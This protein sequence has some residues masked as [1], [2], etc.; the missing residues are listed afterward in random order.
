MSVAWNGFCFFDL[1]IKKHYRFD[2]RVCIFIDIMIGLI[3]AVTGFLNFAYDAVIYFALELA[4]G[5]QVRLEIAAIV[6]LAIAW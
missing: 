3:L 5:Q 2:R 6:F 1:M 4:S